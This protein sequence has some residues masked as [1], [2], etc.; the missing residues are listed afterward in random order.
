MG[1]FS[2]LVDDGVN[3]IRNVAKAVINTTDGRGIAAVSDAMSASALSHLGRDAVN[4]DMGSIA[5]RLIKDGMAEGGVLAGE[6]EAMKQVLKEGNLDS[7]IDHA[8]RVAAK[9][10]DDGVYKA[11]IDKFNSKRALYENFKKAGMTEEAASAYFGRESG[12]GV[13]RTAQGFMS[14]PTRAKVAVG[15]YA[16]AAVGARVLSGGSLTTNNRGERDIVGVPFI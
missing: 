1:A 16:G 10:A 12:V 3:Y 15:A 5:K 6:A 13:L 11:A 4:S 8:S 2:G 14:N 7:L 9:G